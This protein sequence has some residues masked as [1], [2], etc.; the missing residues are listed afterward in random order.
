MHDNIPRTNEQ[1]ARLV[2]VLWLST[3]IF[4]EILCILRSRAADCRIESITVNQLINSS[5]LSVRS[6]IGYKP[7][8]RSS[9]CAHMFVKCHSD[10]L[11]EFALFWFY[12][13]SML[14]SLSVFFITKPCYRK[15]IIGVCWLRIEVENFVF[16][17][18]LWICESSK[19]ASNLL[20]DRN[21]PV[22]FRQKHSARFDYVCVLCR[23]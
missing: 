17:V 14:S 19:Q 23:L 6:F 20:L 5:K 9:I 11:K 10:W 13:S 15:K 22:F 1:L 16:I 12:F 8:S 2:Y 3:V 21:I 4:T 7:I 18:N